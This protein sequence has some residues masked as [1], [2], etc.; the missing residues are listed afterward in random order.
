M[1]RILLLCGLG[2]LFGCNSSL[3][4]NDQFQKALLISIHEQPKVQEAIRKQMSLSSFTLSKT[5][6]MESSVITIDSPR[7]HLSNGVVTDTRTD[8]ST[9]ITILQK[10][11]SCFLKFNRNEPLMVKDLRCKVP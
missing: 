6:F 3:Q 1:K 2:S 9:K 8:T 7:V 10:G 11:T 4:A 5:A